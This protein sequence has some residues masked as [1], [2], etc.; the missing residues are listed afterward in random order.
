MSITEAW[1]RFHQA[2][3]AISERCAGGFLA[4][5]KRKTPT[6]CM[7]L[8]RMLASLS[9]MASRSP[10]I[11]AGTQAKELT[12]IIAEESIGGFPAKVVSPRTSSHGLT[13]VYF[14]KVSGHDALCLWGK[15][16]SATQHDLV[17]K[18]FETIRFGGSVPRYVIP[19]PSAPAKS[20]TVMRQLMGNP[21]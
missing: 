13:G 10:L 15:D 9:G 2:V 1:A 20:G 8:I 3:K 11:L 16:L 19:P 18:M 4:A 5:S 21:S 14:R 12:Y 17:L 6:S 7:E